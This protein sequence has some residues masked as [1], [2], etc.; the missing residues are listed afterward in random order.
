MRI[1][2]INVARTSI[3]G[4][5]S[6][7][8]VESITVLQTGWYVINHS[9]VRRSNSSINLGL[10]GDTKMANQKGI[11]SLIGAMRYYIA[12]FIGDRITGSRICWVVSSK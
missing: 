7:C 12:S 8:I 11:I 3:W 9:T 6:E 2:G 5:S 4:G 10:S 1:F